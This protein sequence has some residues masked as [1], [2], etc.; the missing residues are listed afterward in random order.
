MSNSVAVIIVNWNTGSR[1]TETLLSLKQLPEN[2]QTR[3]SA[4]VVVDNASMDGSVAQAK[5]SG[6][7]KAH[8]IELTTNEGFARANNIGVEYAH[9]RG[10][11]ND[12]IL[13][14]NPDTIVHEGAI[15]N[16][17]DVLEHNERAGIVGPKLLKENGA[18]QRS[19]RAFPSLLVLIAFFSKLSRF[20]SWFPFWKSYVQADFDYEKEQSVDQVMGAA[21]LIRNDVWQSV[22]T[23]DESYWIW[24]EEV[25]YCKRAK[26]AGWDV[27]Y[28]PATTI[29]HFGGVSFDQLIGFSRT[30]PMMNSA[31]VYAKKHLGF[32]SVLVLYVLYPIGLVLTLPAAF[33]HMVFKRKNKERLA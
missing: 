1:L 26:N 22:G 12:H 2:E 15:H 29:T 25:D 30:M 10:M 20:M 27:I 33:A 17:C 21:F 18:V 13:L 7:T 14:L 16:M 6:Y 24:F 31:V 9:E 5:H 32:F 4:V 11:K 3:I 28:T 19:V 23:L 8:F